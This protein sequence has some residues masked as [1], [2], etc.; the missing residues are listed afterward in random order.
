MGGEE[1]PDLVT[2]AVI[3]EAITSTL[4]TPS[5]AGVL[6]NQSVPLEAVGVPIGS[7]MF[8]DY[9]AVPQEAINTS[10]LHQFSAF[11]PEGTTVSFIPQPRMTVGEGGQVDPD[12]VAL[13]TAYMT[14]QL[15]Q[16]GS[17]AGQVVVEGSQPGMEHSYQEHVTF[18]L[19]GSAPMC[20][21]TPMGLAHGGTPAMPSD[22]HPGE[23]FPR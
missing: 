1:R 20:V 9:R 12:Q 22:M 14:A 8:Q 2:P 6:V 3:S 13:G 19:A 16:V 23:P 10:T 15:G 7:D 4:V 5:T 21:P 11:P 17:E 18:P